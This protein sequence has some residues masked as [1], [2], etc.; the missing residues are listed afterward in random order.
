[1]LEDNPDSQDDAIGKDFARVNEDNRLIFTLGGIQPIFSFDRS[2][3]DEFIKYLLDSGYNK[4]LA[5]AA[6]QYYN[7]IDELCR[8]ELTQLDQIGEFDSRFSPPTLYIL[9]ACRTGAM[10]IDRYTLIVEHQSNPTE[11]SSKQVIRFINVIAQMN[12]VNAVELRTLIEW[13][14]NSN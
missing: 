2:E 8:I 13:F 1:M 10:A 9:N 11:E 6:N 5:L 7:S 12:K 4:E 14:E 3:D